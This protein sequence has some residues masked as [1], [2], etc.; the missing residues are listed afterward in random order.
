MPFDV[1]LISRVSDEIENSARRLKQS[2]NSPNELMAEVQKI[3]TS[4]S[5]L[6]SLTTGTNAAGANART[7]QYAPNQNQS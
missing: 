3:E 4:I 1:S 6:K 7:A 5:S 2:A